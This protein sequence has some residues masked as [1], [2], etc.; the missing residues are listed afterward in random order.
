MELHDTEGCA[1]C[2]ENTS[3]IYPMNAVA[4]VGRIFGTYPMHMDV[5]HSLSITDCFISTSKRTRV[6]VLERYSG[7]CYVLLKIHEGLCT[8]QR[9]LLPGHLKKKP[10][11][12]PMNTAGS[13]T[14]IRST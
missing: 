12:Y 11:D 3:N 13:V 6:Y 2:S 10:C 4:Y 1:T 9:R 5:L 14:Q 8:V 7:V